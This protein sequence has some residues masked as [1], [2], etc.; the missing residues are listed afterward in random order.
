[1][2]DCAHCSK[3]RGFTLIELLVVIAIIALLIGILLP[4]INSARKVARQTICENNLKTFGNS[5][6]TYSADFK[7]TIFSFSWQ[8][9]DA[10]DPNYRKADGST[11]AK[12]NTDLVAAAQQAVT[13]IASRGDRPDMKPISSWIPHYYYT[14][15][16]LQDYLNS[17][18]PEKLVVCPEDRYR[19]SWHNDPRPPAWPKQYIPRPGSADD[20]ANGYRWPYSSSYT[21]VVSS[22]DRSSVGNRISQDGGDWG[23]FSVPNGAELGNAKFH[24]V[25]FPSSK[26]VVFDEVQRHYGQ[27]S[28]WSYD[29]VRQPFAFFDASVRTQLMKNCNRGWKPNQPANKGASIISYTETTDPVH[30]FWPASRK[31][32]GD[33]TFGYFEYTR[34][35]L[36]GL[37]FGGAEVNTG[38]GN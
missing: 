1:M 9:H 12:A 2:Q 27:P 30:H 15:L 6:G 3:D 24:S 37:D 23:G 19:L 21:Y 31:P 34:G 25:L 22:F 10:G 36:A 29:D 35:G 20:G 32:A 26:V 8:A 7:D 38:Q 11:W 28:W 16:V 5:L 17:R 13:I 18:L 14:H 4:A 33:L